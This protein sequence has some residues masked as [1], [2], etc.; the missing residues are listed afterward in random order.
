MGS[1]ETLGI[2]NENSPKKIWGSKKIRGFMIKISN[3][4]MGVPDD[5]LVSLKSPI[6]SLEVSDE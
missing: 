6:K 2:R 4:N 3:E 1:N 5:N